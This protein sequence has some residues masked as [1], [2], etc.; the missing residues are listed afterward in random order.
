VLLLE[1]K[2]LIVQGV[3]TV[4]HGLHQLYLGVSQAV[5]VGNV[6]GASGLATRLSTGATG[7]HIQLLAAFL[8]GIHTF[9]GPSGQVNVHG[10]SHTCSQ[11]G[12]A[13]VQVTELGA[14]LE[15]FARFCF[16]AVTDRVDSEC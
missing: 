3:D 5:L 11:V 13:G 2:I 4:N 6:I 9:G 7:L 12:G 16:D 1:V 15:A 10:G 14:K 8:E